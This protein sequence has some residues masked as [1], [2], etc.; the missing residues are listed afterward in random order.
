MLTIVLAVI[1][2][3][4]IFKLFKEFGKANHVM[5]NLSEE[6]QD[7]LQKTVEN[8]IGSMKQNQSNNSNEIQAK[9]VNQ[10]DFIEDPIAKDVAALQE[11]IPN[12]LPVA[13]LNKAEE[14]FDMIFNAFANSHHHILKAMLTERLYEIFSDQIQKKVDSDLRQEILIKHKKTTLDQVQLLADKV[15]LWVSFDVSQMS[16]MI[17]SDGVSF[18]N[19]KHLYRDVIHKWIFERNFDEDNWILS[20]TSSV[21]K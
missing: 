9:I 21:E 10:D 4:I 13:F 14:M 8:I 11:K 16:A 19:P 3:L 6:E 17:N 20:K 7:K 5:K 1:S 15:K 2:F 12:F 18:D